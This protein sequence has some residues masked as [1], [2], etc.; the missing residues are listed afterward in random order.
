ML[1]RGAQQVPP[2]KKAQQLPP[3]ACPT[4]ILKLH[5]KCATP[6]PQQLPPP[7]HVPP[8]SKCPHF[9]YSLTLRVFILNLDEPFFL[10]SLLKRRSNSP[11][12]SMSP[13]FAVTFSFKQVEILQRQTNHRARF[14]RS[15]TSTHL[16]I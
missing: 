5:V 2:P 4:Q 9:S 16:N 14:R 6:P 12:R 1:L 7:Q 3:A 15:I 10:M 13:L 8:R 11:H